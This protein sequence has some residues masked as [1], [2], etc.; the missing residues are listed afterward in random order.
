M[1]INIT[2]PYTSNAIVHVTLGNVLKAVVSF[3]GLMI[4]RVVVKGF[5]EML[6]LWKESRYKVYQRVTDHAHA[7]MLHFYNPMFPD[8]SVKSFLVRNNLLFFYDND[9]LV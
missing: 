3:K 8:L 9:F 1:G 7:A 5:N 4:E 6:D 2:R